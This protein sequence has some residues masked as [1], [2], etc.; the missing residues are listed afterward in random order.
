LR[1]YKGSGLVLKGIKRNALYLFEGV[2]LLSSAGGASTCHQEMAVADRH[3]LVGESSELGMSM[4]NCLTCVEG[5][6]LEDDKHGVF[7]SKHWCELSIGAHHYLLGKMIIWLLLGCLFYGFARF[8]GLGNVQHHTFGITSWQNGVTELVGRIKS[9]GVLCM[10]L[11]TWLVSRYWIGFK[12]GIHTG[13]EVTSW[14]VIWVCCVSGYLM[15]EVLFRLWC[16]VLYLADA[17]MGDSG[18][19]L[20]VE[21]VVYYSLISV[22]LQFGGFDVAPG[23]SLAVISFAI[24]I[25]VDSLKESVQ[26]AFHQL[27]GFLEM[28]ICAIE[29]S[30]RLV[31]NVVLVAMR[32]VGYAL[33]LV[34]ITRLVAIFVESLGPSPYEHGVEYSEW[35][36][37]FAMTL[38]INKVWELSWVP[39]SKKLMKFL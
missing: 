8:W 31:D 18:T 7:E 12:W 2:T 32:V 22:L 21:Y 38:R 6:Y 20:K 19:V 5:A 35:M 26:C 39:D 33:N 1:V 17:L 25:S 37:W 30:D 9:W 24:F 23:V 34:V 27:R 13:I 16:S 14:C 36:H 3:V 11:G 28:P 15:V 10:L 29:E 4:G